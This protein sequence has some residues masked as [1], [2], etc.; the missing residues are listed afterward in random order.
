MEADAK[1]IAYHLKVDYPSF[2]PESDSSLSEINAIV[3]GLIL[4]HVGE[5]RLSVSHPEVRDDL[6]ERGWASTQDSLRIMF[7]VHLLTADLVSISFLISH[8]GAGAAH[9]MYHTRTMNF[10]RRPVCPLSTDTIFR[11]DSLPVLSDYCYQELASQLSRI[12]MIPN[13]R[14]GGW[15]SN[16]VSPKRENFRALVLTKEGATIFFDPYQVGPFAIGRMEV[17]VTRSVIE[18]LMVPGVRQIFSNVD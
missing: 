12:G 4:Q 3:Y 7:D 6:R 17:R 13:E 8:Y 10:L 18:P 11:P 5:R 14:Q 15:L 2:Q 1:Q 9:Q 16:G